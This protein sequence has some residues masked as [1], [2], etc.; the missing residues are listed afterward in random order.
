MTGILRTQTRTRVHTRGKNFKKVPEMLST[1]AFCRLSMADSLMVADST[2]TT[3]IIHTCMHQSLPHQQR[4]VKQPERPQAAGVSCS[5][6]HSRD[7]RYAGGMQGGSEELQT[8]HKQF[9]K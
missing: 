7:G 1:M 6:S 3:T 4:A 9:F 5:P 8:S 2:A